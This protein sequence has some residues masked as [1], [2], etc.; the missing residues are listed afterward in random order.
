[1]PAAAQTVTPH[2]RQKPQALKT[3]ANLQNVKF[4]Q[5]TPQRTTPPQKGI[6]LI[7]QVNAF[8]FTTKDKLKK[9]FQL[10]SIFNFQIERK[11]FGFMSIFSTENVCLERL[12]KPMNINRFK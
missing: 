10:R 12:N 9:S 4:G 8:V 6:W 5:P 7:C 1:V 3:P 11:S 2:Q